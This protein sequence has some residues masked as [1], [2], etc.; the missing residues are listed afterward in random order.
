VRNFQKYVD[1]V[2]VQAH[3]REAHCIRDVASYFVLRRQTIGAIPSL[4]LLTLEMDLD[5]EV[6]EHPVLA[7]LL[8]LC[9]DMILIGNDLYSYN[10]E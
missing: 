4:D 7:K 6:V 3:D 9:V 5:D 8:E 1:A 2:V 10:I